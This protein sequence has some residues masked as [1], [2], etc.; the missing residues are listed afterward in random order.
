MTTGG[1]MLTGNQSAPATAINGHGGW[2]RGIV[3]LSAP[4]RLPVPVA[5]FL[6]RTSLLGASNQGGTEHG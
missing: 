6:A 1:R 2:H 5:A 4:G 3:A